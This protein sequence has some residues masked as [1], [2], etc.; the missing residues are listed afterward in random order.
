MNL[1]NILLG[2]SSWKQRDTFCVIPFYD[3]RRT[4]KLI[5]TEGKL[6]VVRNRENGGHLLTG[7]LMD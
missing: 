4:G 7:V 3:L 1:E 6:V 2:E 5:E